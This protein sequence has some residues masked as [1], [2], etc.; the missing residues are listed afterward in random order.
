MKSHLFRRLAAC[1]GAV[2]LVLAVA[3]PA[4]ADGPYHFQQIIT[5]ATPLTCPNGEQIP[6]ITVTTIH[7]LSFRDTSNQGTHLFFHMLVDASFV[8]PTGIIASGTHVQ[9][10]QL[11][12][13]TRAFHLQGVILNLRVGHTIVAH[14]AGQIR[15]DAE[16]NAR[17][18]PTFDRFSIDTLCSALLP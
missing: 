15:I 1:I 12:A 10:E 8:G 9:T 7:G 17:F 5:D 3:T 6:G 4:A 18:S 11:D 2:L 16:G 14:L 13:T